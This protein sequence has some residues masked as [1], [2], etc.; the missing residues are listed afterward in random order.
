MR[1]RITFTK[2]G[3]LK[4]ISHLDLMRLWERALRRARI[5]VAYSR[6]FN[7]RPK[8][9]FAAALPLGFASRG[10]VMDVVLERRLS[11]HHFVQRVREQLP[12][13]VELL[14]VE[15]VHPALPSLQSQVRFAEYRVVVASDES[16]AEME[17]RLE[18]L[19]RAQRLPRRRRRKEYDLRPLIDAL[20]I[21]GEAPGGTLIGMRLRVGE[22]GT[23]RPDEVLDELGLAERVVS[24][25]RERLLFAS[26]G[27]QTGV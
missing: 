18:R 15:E 23:G 11:P 25:Q 20:W 5:P 26:S 24:I 3:E 21:E 19:L 12:R 17:A 2:L 22:G 16:R 8:I 1:L 27:A 9:T 4:Y 14:D 10:E 13:G 7:P 6:G